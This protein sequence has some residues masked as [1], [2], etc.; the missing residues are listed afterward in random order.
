M[1]EYWLLQAA[2]EGCLPCVQRPVRAGGIDVDSTSQTQRY[3]AMDCA[4]WAQDE[5][6]AGAEEVVAFLAQE[7]GVNAASL[8]STRQILLAPAS[9]PGIPEGHGKKLLLRQ[10]WLPGQG[11]GKNNH[12]RREP[13]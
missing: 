4:V 9:D 1:P 8:S 5:G 6:V 10:G 11:L 7:P 2:N 3:T 13:V 12:G